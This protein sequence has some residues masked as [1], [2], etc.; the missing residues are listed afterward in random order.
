M[1]LPKSAKGTKEGAKSN[2]VILGVGWAV[3]RTLSQGS[4]KALQR[5]V[6]AQRKAKRKQK[7]RKT[8]L[9]LFLLGGIVTESERHNLL[10]FI[11]L[12]VANAVAHSDG[13][14]PRF[15]GNNDGDSVRFLGQTEGSA[16]P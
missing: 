12:N 14:M 3:S 5:L 8:N 6:P 11:V 2:K 7:G 13:N 9:L 4:P 10:Q 1:E 15:F 16:V